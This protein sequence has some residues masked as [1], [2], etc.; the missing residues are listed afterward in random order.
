MNNVCRGKKKIFYDVEARNGRYVILDIGNVL[1]R[2]VAMMLVRPIGL[3][4]SS[5]ETNCLLFL[6]FLSFLSF[7]EKRIF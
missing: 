5:C 4:I 6:L 3:L 1:S 7:R 2:R